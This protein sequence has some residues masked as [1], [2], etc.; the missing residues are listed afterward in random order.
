MAK[1]RKNSK[2]RPLRTNLNSVDLTLIRWMARLTPTQRLAVLQD[3]IKLV[4][5]YRRA[6]TTDSADTAD[7]REGAEA[8]V[9]KR[10]PQFKGQ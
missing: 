9:E 10:K 8:F 7:A 5:A 3:H 4:S 6:A 2:G 1:R